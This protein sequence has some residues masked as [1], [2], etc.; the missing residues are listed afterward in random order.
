MQTNKQTK[1]KCVTLRSARSYSPSSGSLLSSG[2]FPSNRSATTRASRR[3]RG[4]DREGVGVERERRR[5]REKGIS[6]SDEKES[7]SYRIAINEYGRLRVSI[8]T[9]IFFSLLS[10]PASCSPPCGNNADGRKKER[11]K[12]VDVKCWGAS[13]LKR[14]NRRAVPGACRAPGARLQYH[15]THSAAKIKHVRTLLPLRLEAPILSSLPSSF[16]LFFFPPNMYATSQSQSKDHL[17]PSNFYSPPKN[18]T[19]IPGVQT[20]ARVRN[21]SRMFV[22]LILI[23]LR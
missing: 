1:K 13:E 19:L 3:E 2:F 15:V 18:W 12:W 11:S 14:R 4:E 8:L 22:F 6:W 9:E 5:E 21:I 16:I 17:P 7:E 23:I 20:S 10:C